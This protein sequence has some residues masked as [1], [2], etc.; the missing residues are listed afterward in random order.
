MEELNISML[1]IGI[2]VIAHFVLGFLWYTPIFGKV[3]AKEMGFDPN[4]SEEERK[5]MMSGMMKGM[6]SML[7]GNF[8]L[9]YVFSHNIAAWDFVPGMDEMSKGESAMMAAMFTWLGFFL[10]TD[11]GTMFWE[12]RSF[13][14]FAINT[15][16]HLASLILV[17]III[18]FMR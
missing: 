12:K 6:I 1:A 16:Y 17:A 18:T 3:W 11:A 14:L 7:I 9:A 4:P 2:A 8:L 15:S 5:A 10:P 13:K